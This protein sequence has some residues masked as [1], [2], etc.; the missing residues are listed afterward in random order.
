M[1][2]INR[3]VKNKFNFFTNFFKKNT[4]CTKKTIK[5]KIY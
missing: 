2:E 5:E 1:K 4:M 3:F